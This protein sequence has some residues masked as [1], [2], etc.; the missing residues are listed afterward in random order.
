MPADPN[1]QRLL[2]SRLQLSEARVGL[3]SDA[4]AVDKLDS[5]LGR[6]L[7][8]HP[9]RPWE[10]A[11]VQADGTRRVL[12]PRVPI[13]VM[14]V[15]IL[16]LGAGL[17]LFDDDLGLR[18]TLGTVCTLLAVVY[19]VKQ[20]RVE[21]H[22]LFDATRRLAIIYRGHRVLVEIPF[23]DIDAIYVEVEANPGYAD[24]YRAFASIGPVSLPL[25]FSTTDTDVLAA[26]DTVGNLVGITREPALRRRVPET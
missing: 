25:T 18:I 26:A 8:D 1:R 15:L 11:L 23:E 6:T 12:E 5:W 10:L 19:Y 13:W 20:A 17:V 14:P 21:R 2:A 9:S 3:F 22:L 4:S 16:A 24:R 7:Y